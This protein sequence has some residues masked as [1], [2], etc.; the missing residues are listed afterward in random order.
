MRCPRVRYFFPGF[1]VALVSTWLVLRPS[2]SADVAAAPPQAPAPKDV[3]GTAGVDPFVETVKPIF[4][5]YCLTCHNDKKRSG[6][7]TLEPFTDSVSTRKERDLWEKV[8]ENVENK[9]MPPKGKPQPTDAERQS[10]VTWID[11]VA[12]RVDCSGPRD[13]G[14]PT[15]RRLNRFE[16]NNTIRDLIGVDS[17]PADVFPSDDVGYGFDNIGDVL[18]MPPILLEKYLAAAEKVLD[19][20]VVVPKPI[21]VS[22]DGFRP[23]NVRTTLGPFARQMNN[24]RI[25][26]T[27]NGSAYFGYDFAY[28]GEYIL[29][30]RAYGEQAGDE[31]PKLVIQ[32]DKKP[33]ATHNVEAV[34]AKPASYEGRVKV[35]AG[36]HEVA[37]AFTNDFED[38]EAKDE[39]KRDRNLYIEVMEVEGPFNP[40]PKP[41]PESHK[42]IFVATAAGPQEQDS[43]ARTIIERFATR[44]YRR[45]VKADEVAR[46]LKLYQF[47][48]GQKEQFEQSVK[49]ALKAVLVSPHFLFRIER[50]AEPNN[51]QAIH[52][53]GQYELATRLSYFLWSSMP[54]DELY[55][56]ADRGKLW[57]PAV[58]E[59]QVRRML[60]DPKA[61]AL[62]ENFAGQWLMLRTFVT[63]TP[64]RRTYRG[65]DEPLRAAMARETELYFDH[66]MREDRSVLEFL[67]SDYTFLNERLAR[68]YGI[69]G[70][71]GSEFRK[72]TLTDKSRGGLLTHGSILTVTSNPTRTSPV[73]R[74][75]WIL[76]NILGTP[77]PPPPPDVPD[78]EEDS[79]AVLTGS[80]RK[81]MEKHRENASCAVCH[82]KLDPLGFGLENFDGVGAFRE[83]DGKFKIDA[84]GELPDGSKFSGPAELRKVLLKRADLF[85]KNLAEKLLT[86]ALGRG[87]EYY[88]KCAVDEI[89]TGLKKGED[90]FSALMIAVARTDAFQKRRGG[91]GPTK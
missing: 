10:I 18:S 37:F 83:M 73:K 12:T 36:R 79:H 65:F 41:L 59:A 2:P 49:H 86:Y 54:D 76:E 82:A 67:D 84:S 90:R 3:A 44:A 26:L 21:I 62:G 22:K 9:Q 28:E 29:R 33:V 87:L 4:S 19:A 27:Q 77:P 51:P 61:A 80:L 89:V 13:P 25:G 16:Y 71:A 81:R 85:R 23:Q 15:I 42:R 11:T 48:A 31:L 50:D 68:H 53:V 56:L 14:R 58:L 66:V 32:L 74:G 69:S 1:F 7:M 24:R 46:L 91:S 39:K 38:K 45:P 64:D 63:M 72:V 43:V 88:D 55:G 8:K 52:P 20:A 5:K 17:R 78:L 34:Q 70:V 47:A 75:K 60:K 40:V 30:A 6:D 57:E 35:T